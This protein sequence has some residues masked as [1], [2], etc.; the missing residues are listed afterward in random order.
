VRGI[1]EYTSQADAT[2]IPSHSIVYWEL[3]VREGG[4]WPE[5]DVFKRCCGVTAGP[6]VPQRRHHQA[7]GTGGARR[8]VQGHD[9]LYSISCGVFTNQYMAPRR[10]S[11]G[12]IIELL[13]S[14]VVLS[15][16]LSLACPS[17]IPYKK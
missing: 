14:R 17:Y 7:P 15:K 16:H 6:Q 13:N 11:F 12:P 8:H 9:G 3:M 1:V 4:V 5:A 2:T 10:V